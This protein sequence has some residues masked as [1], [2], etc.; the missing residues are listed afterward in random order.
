MVGSTIGRYKIVDRLGAGGMGEVYKA[1]DTT[2]GRPVALKFLAAHL[3][4]DDEA[5]QRFLREAKAA[6]AITHPGICHVYEVGEE[7]GKTFL[8]MVFLEGEPLEDRIEKGPLPLKDALDIGR[9]IAEALEAAHEKEIVHRDIKPANVMVDAKGRAT[10]LDFGLAR[11]AEASKLTRANQTVG[12]AAYMSPE[13]IQ[14]TEVDHRTDVWAVGCVLYEMVAGVRPFKGEYDQALAYEIVQEEPEPLTGVRA[15]LPMELEFIVGK[16]LAKEADERYSSA[17]DLAKDLSR[18]QKQL[19]SGRSRLSS[20]RTRPADSGQESAAASR[21]PSRA[22]W[23]AAAGAAVLA[24]GLGLLVPSGEESRPTPA[25]RLEAPLP[26]GVNPR[27]LALS[28]DGRTI[29]AVGQSGGRTALWRRPMDGLEFVEI[30]DTE[31]ASYPFW[32]PDSQWIGFFA[33]GQLKKVAVVGG[34]PQ[35][36]CE[37]PEGRGGTWNRDDV[38]V[39]SPGPLADLQRVSALGGEPADLGFADS[40]SVLRFPSFLPDGRRFLLFARARSDEDL[41][42]AVASLTGDPPRPILT[43]A[44]SSAYLSG[45]APGDGAI[46]FVRDGTLFAQTVDVQLE[47]RGSAAPVAAGIASGQ[48]RSAYSFAAD[49]AGTIVY[50]ATQPE[51]LRSQL[52][53]YDRLGREIERA[54]EPAPSISRLRLSP[55]ESQ[56]VVHGPSGTR[57][58]DVARTVFTPFTAGEIQPL[59]P[60][61]SPGGAS[62]TFTLSGN[63]IISGIYR[64]RIAS[65]GNGELVA[66]RSARFRLTL[67]PL[68]WSSDGRFLLFGAQGSSGDWNLFAMES[69]GPDAPFPVVET[70]RD[71]INARF[72]P[73]A[74][75]IVYQSFESGRSEIYVQSFPV[76]EQRRQVSSGGGSS[77]IWSHDGREVFYVRPDNMLIATSVDLDQDVAIGRSEELFP[78]KV[79]L[80]LLGGVPYDVA[81]DGRRFLVAELIDD[82]SPTITVVTDWRAASR[83]D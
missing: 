41:S 14:G 68:A 69:E 23:A 47:P 63:D 56:V 4:N 43:G 37:A 2:L 5:K 18:Q 57:I 25:Y 32:S 20:V 70:R 80:G 79:P 77:P 54:S 13:Q 45:D 39:F 65:A 73:N 38:I 60:V 53:W 6:A 58:F 27:G 76:G 26:E 81:N 74:D 44:S 16:C 64:R 3:L 33:E 49:D 50:A 1:E 66:Q 75:W 46:L 30:P 55:D 72:S 83:S 82:G 29:V 62:L 52:I 59:F 19:D 40:F 8:A 35:T 9:Q 22:V 78:V 28:P 42:I 7:N 71:D 31:G 17:G 11:L 34:P 24:F 48:N 61:W 21:R 67:A 51:F 15:G 12:T 10:I 36:L